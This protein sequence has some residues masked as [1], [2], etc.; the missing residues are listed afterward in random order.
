[1]LETI[2][3]AVLADLAIVIIIALI[4]RGTGK[5]LPEWVAGKKVA[6]WVNN[7]IAGD[8]KRLDRLVSAFSL[9]G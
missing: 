6:R 5:R 3:L 9:P 4:C 2:A 7:L 8:P 1:M